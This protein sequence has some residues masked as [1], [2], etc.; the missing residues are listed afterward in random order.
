MASEKATLS[1]AL[2]THIKELMTKMEG[3]SAL[4]VC[5]ILSRSYYLDL[6]I[7]TRILLF[8]LSVFFQK[9]HLTPQKTKTEEFLV[10]QEEAALIQ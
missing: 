2:E 1:N 4:F 6:K 7:M 3:V 10:S 9:V 8:D 5:P